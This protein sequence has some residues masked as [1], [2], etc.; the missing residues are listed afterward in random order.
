MEGSLSSSKHGFMRRLVTFAIAVTATAL[1][2]VVAPTRAAAQEVQRSGDAVTGV[3]IANNKVCLAGGTWR[4]TGTTYAATGDVKLT[5]PDAKVSLS[6]GNASFSVGKTLA[7]ASFDLTAQVGFDGA[8]PLEGW[9]FAGPGAAIAVGQGKYLTTRTSFPLGESA[10]PKLQEKFYVYV[11]FPGNGGITVTAPSGVQVNAGPSIPGGQLLIGFDL[12]HPAQLSFYLGGGFTSLVSRGIVDSG[13]VFVSL[14]KDKLPTTLDGFRTSFDGDETVSKTVNSSFAVGGSIVLVTKA[15]PLNLSGDLLFDTTGNKLNAAAGKTSLAV[16]LGGY[17]IT[18]SVPLADA[19]FYVEPAACGGKGDVLVH[20]GAAPPNLFA[21]AGLQGFSLASYSVDAHVCGPDDVLVQLRARTA[22]IAGFTL[23]KLKVG[24]SPSGVAV[25]GDLA[26]AGATYRVTGMID[27]TTKKIRLFTSTALKLYGH[28]LADGSIELT[29]QGL[30]AAVRVQGDLDFGGK[31]YHLDKT[32]QTPQPTFELSTAVSAKGSVDV[33]LGAPIFTGSASFDVR[34][35]ANVRL[36]PPPQGA[37]LGTLTCA[38]S[39][40][41]RGTGT[42]QFGAASASAGGSVVIRGTCGETVSGSARICGTLPAQGERCGQFQVSF[43]NPTYATPPPARPQPAPL[44]APRGGILAPGPNLSQQEG[45]TYTQAQYSVQGDVVTLAGT[46]RNV[47][48]P[49]QNLK[50]AI[51][52]RLPEGARPTR[53]LVFRAPVQNGRDGAIEGG[54][55]D[56]FPNGYVVFMDGNAEASWVQLTGISFRRHR[57]EDAPLQPGYVPYV[58]QGSTL[59]DP[60]D[61][62]VPNVGGEGQIIRL[63]GLVKRVAT[64][65]W[66]EIMRLPQSM[67]PVKTIAVS[68]AANGGGARLDISPSGA[69]TWAG[70]PP[71]SAWVSLSGIEFVRGE[72]APPS[73]GLTN[74]RNTY[75]PRDRNGMTQMALEHMSPRAYLDNGVVRLDGTSAYGQSPSPQMGILG[76]GFRPERNLLFYLHNGAQTLKYEVTA[77]NGWINISQN[78]GDI[79]PLVGI[80]FHPAGAVQ[81]PGARPP[82]QSKPAAPAPPQ[83]K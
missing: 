13:Y 9:K 67:R 26:F 52:T 49:P 53:R 18:A 41:G 72:V 7:S 48:T 11:S 21:D 38:L 79:G 23:G 25:E 70:G 68:A 4:D 75:V 59:G 45:T 37:V 22:T 77:S 32:V 63:Q 60:R 74:T 76:A 16:D 47:N 30:Q 34:G 83:L 65:P 29:I 62:E 71:T 3:C 35:S 12:A 31:R 73:Q 15:I 2:L 36:E 64:G 61:Y 54:R 81:M 1:L 46:L 8:G 57:G 56:I 51:L 44:P 17:G 39:G 66:G 5:I 33:T 50:G 40:A 55:I 43:P 82:L 28:T 20:V 19:S 27:P 58:S 14:G 6:L 42:V 10:L 80:R 78:S 24:F 69:V